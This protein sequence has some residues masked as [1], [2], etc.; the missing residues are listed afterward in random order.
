VSTMKS[1]SQPYT[2]PDAM[3]SEY[4]LASL[5]KDLA[6]T[7][8][9]TITTGRHRLSEMS[10]EMPYAGRKINPLWTLLSNRLFDIIATVGL[11]HAGVLGMLSSL[12]NGPWLAK[13]LRRLL[14]AIGLDSVLGRLGAEGLLAALLDGEAWVYRLL[15]EMSANVGDLLKAFLN[16][17]GLHGVLEWMRVGMVS[18]ALELER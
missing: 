11:L 7:V 5:L 6:R 12:L 15:E 18:E 4:R 1:N 3:K 2:V 8:I 13:V 14:V 17:F 9:D 16:L 10:K